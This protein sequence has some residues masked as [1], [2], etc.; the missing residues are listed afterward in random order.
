MKKLV[1]ACSLLA[2][3]TACSSTPKTAPAE[4]AEARRATEEKP[5]SED[6][7]PI[8]Y[9]RQDGTVRIE[10]GNK[11]G[12]EGEDYTALEEY[13]SQ[14]ARFMHME[15]DET[16]KL[17]LPDDPIVI[18]ADK[19]TP[20]RMIQEIMLLCGKLGIEVWKV[21]LTATQPERA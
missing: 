2:A 15:W 8:L 20:F 14:K 13:L 3:A 7:Q 5:D 11:F 17:D 6:R 10:C 9:I 16:L 18:R 19:S 1:I 21:Q 4:R 12:P